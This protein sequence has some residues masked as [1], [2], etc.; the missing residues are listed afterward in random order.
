MN[1]CEDRYLKLGSLV[2][3][4]C[5]TAVGGFVFLCGSRLVE[6]ENEESAAESS[7]PVD[8]THKKSLA[9]IGAALLLLTFVMNEAVVMIRA[10]CR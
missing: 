8:D 5:A 1:R 3:N 4:L 6:A 2:R 7:I 10:L 9:G